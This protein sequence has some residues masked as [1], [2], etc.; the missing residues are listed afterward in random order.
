MKT[1]VFSTWSLGLVLIVLS[2]AVGC[3]QQAAN[4]PEISK[5]TKKAGTEPD[6]TTQTT[7]DEDFAL[8]EPT[9]EAEPSDAPAKPVSREK[10]IPPSIRPTSPL[11]EVITLADSGV[12]ERV[13]LE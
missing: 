2:L 7:A 8:A 4:S 3:L 6:A 12:D 5:S 13:M 9:P 1:R 11:A 10:T